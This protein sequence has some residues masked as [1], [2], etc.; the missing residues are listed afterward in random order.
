M[1]LLLEDANTK[2][3]AIAALSDVGVEKKVDVKLV[4]ADSLAKSFH[5]LTNFCNSV[6]TQS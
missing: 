3:V 6:K 1:I 5:S 2:L 4:T